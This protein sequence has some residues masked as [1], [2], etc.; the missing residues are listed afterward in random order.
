MV[1]ELREDDPVLDAQPSKSSLAGLAVGVLHEPLEA[2]ERLGEG[3]LRL[4][5]ESAAVVADDHAVVVD[6]QGVLHGVSLRR[7]HP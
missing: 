7:L 3:G 2:F 4:V 5:A 1:P 6:E